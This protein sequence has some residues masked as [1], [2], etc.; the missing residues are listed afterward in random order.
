MTAGPP[1]DPIQGFP[2]AGDGTFEIPA[3]LPGEYELR[4]QGRGFQ[5]RVA[6]ITMN[7]DGD[8]VELGTMT[9][10]PIPHR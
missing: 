7:S 3:V 8:A 4:F 6:K 2:T 1:N 10:S 9:L 5:T